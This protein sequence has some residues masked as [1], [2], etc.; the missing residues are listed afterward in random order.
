MAVI[1][2]GILLLCSNIDSEKKRK[3]DFFLII[4][5]STV[6]VGLVT[7]ATHLGN[8][9]NALYIFRGV[10]RSPLSTE[11]FF[12]VVFLLFGG[13]Y[14]LWTFKRK[15]NR[16]IKTIWL[17]L[18][19]LA[20]V[21][22][23][24]TIARAY[25]VH[26]IISWDNLYVPVGVIANALAGG[27]LLAALTL[28]LAGHTEIRDKTGI[29]ILSVSF[30]GAVLSAVITMLQAID[31]SH[32]ETAVAQ[33]KELA[34]WFYGALSVFCIFT[35]ITFT[36]IIVEMLG[37]RQKTSLTIRLS[38]SCALLFLGIFTLRLAFYA[39]HLTV[40]L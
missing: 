20:S 6:I 25:S 29:T 8:P 24:I 27:A 2:I 9:A 33:G 38:I 7:S 18:L 22:F 4:P 28:N 35:V 5:L 30:V 32:I 10:G 21:V 13:I 31:I 23:I 40:G 36:M 17:C 16:S 3:L 39:V 15:Q 14:W 37:V 11:V 1:V 12:A 26:T 19:I 34:I